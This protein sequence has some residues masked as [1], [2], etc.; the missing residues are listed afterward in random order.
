MVRKWKRI[1]VGLLATITAGVLALFAL[2]AHIVIIVTEPPYDFGDV[3]YLAGNTFLM[4]HMSIGVSS[5]WDNHKK[6]VQKN[7]AIRF[8]ITDEGLSAE[9]KW[10]E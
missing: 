7:T 8:R 4:F 5:L 6:M 10:I 2:A 1:R 9:R 3:V